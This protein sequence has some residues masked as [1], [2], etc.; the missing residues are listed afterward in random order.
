ML[1]CSC[2]TKAIA[3]ANISKGGIKMAKIILGMLVRVGAGVGLRVPITTVN[4]EGRIYQRERLLSPGHFLFGSVEG[5][6]VEEKKKIDLETGVTIKP[7][8]EVALVRWDGSGY[9][10]SILPVEI[11]TPAAQKI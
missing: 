8:K 3:S 10:T 5:I 11:L 7:A 9:R 2:R 6:Y 4:R 1:L